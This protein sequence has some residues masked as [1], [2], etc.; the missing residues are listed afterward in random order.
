MYIVHVL[1]EGVH[2]MYIWNSDDDGSL[3]KNDDMITNDNFHENDNIYILYIYIWYD[4]IG[5]TNMYKQIYHHHDYYQTKY[6]IDSVYR[7]SV[8][9]LVLFFKNAACINE[10]W[11]RLDKR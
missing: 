9:K 6:L 3:M 5:Y 2:S 11:Q 10:I 7:G 1:Y 8:V 4:M